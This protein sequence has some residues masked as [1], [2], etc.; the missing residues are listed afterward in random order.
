M[1]FEFEIII[2]L[3]QFDDLA[4]SWIERAVREAIFLG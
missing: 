1:I 3:L 4:K 2:L